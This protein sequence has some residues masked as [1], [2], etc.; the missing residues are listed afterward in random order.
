[1]TAE[2]YLETCR[3]NSAISNKFDM[4][5]MD[6]AYKAVDMARKEEREMYS[7][8]LSMKESDHKR[9][10]ES[11]ENAIKGKALAAFRTIEMYVFSE[12]E[13]GRRPT[14]L[15]EKFSKLMDEHGEYEFS[16]DCMGCKVT[17]SKEE[18]Q[19]LLKK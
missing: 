11:V 16:K 8:M 17:I 13:Q 18:I 12:L 9:E 6:A 19:K 7:D 5:Y 3:C 2:E 4:C 14:H 15:Q 1:M 10:I